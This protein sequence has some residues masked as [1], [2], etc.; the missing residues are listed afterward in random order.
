MDTFTPATS[1]PS[2]ALLDAIETFLREGH[3]DLHDPAPP[4]WAVGEP[5]PAGH[6]TLPEGLMLY[7]DNVP[8]LVEAPYL[9]IG[10]AADC[11]RHVPDDDRIWDIP[12]VLHLVECIDTYVS[13]DTPQVLRELQNDLFADAA[14]MEP[15]RVDYPA[16][17]RLSNDELHVYYFTDIRLQKT[18]LF[19]NHPAHTLM[20]K[21]RC[22][23]KTV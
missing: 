6:F 20:A 15:S 7:R 14:I 19:N 9:L 13:D 21:V 10:I 22:A 16:P 17:E 18:Q 11:E 3:P 4:A 8:E 23:G 2:A 5:C 1:E 12:V